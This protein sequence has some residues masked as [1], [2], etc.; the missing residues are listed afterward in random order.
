MKSMKQWGL[1]NWV[2][3]LFLEDAR[4][5]STEKGNMHAYHSFSWVPA[6]PTRL[7]TSHEHACIDDYCQRVYLHPVSRFL[8]HV[9]FGWSLPF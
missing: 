8:S 1:Q 2:K 6:V 3:R 5:H 9:D 4:D 7:D